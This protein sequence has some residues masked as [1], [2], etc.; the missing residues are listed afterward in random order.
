M[1]ANTPSL[2]TLAHGFTFS[3][4][5]NSIWPSWKFHLLAH[6]F[7]GLQTRVDNPFSKDLQIFFQYVGEDIQR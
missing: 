1:Y 3:F 2:L 6:N 5:S 7:L 4:K